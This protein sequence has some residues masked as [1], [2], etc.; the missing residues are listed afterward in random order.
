MTTPDHIDEGL[1]PVADAKPQPTNL[2][3]DNFVEPPFSVLE[4][5]SGSWIEEDRKWRALGIE[6]EIGRDDGLTFNMGM[7]FMHSQRHLESAQQ[8]SRTSVFS[9]HLC[10][11]AYASYSGP[12]HR[13][14]D[15]FAGGSV[16]GIVAGA[17][18]RAYT[19]IELRPEQVEAN[20]AQ[21]WIV[22]DGIEPRWIVGD[23]ATVLP[24]LAEDHTF[25]ADMIFSCPPYAHLEKYSDDPA[26]LS[27]MSYPDFLDAYRGIIRDSVALL[28]PNR[29]AAWVVSE[30][31]GKDGSYL[32]LVP[33][34]IRAFRDA[35]MK[36]HNDQVLLT[37]IG[38]AAVRARKQWETSRKAARVHEYML[39]FVKGDARKATAAAMGEA[40]DD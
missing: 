39:V 17:M 6:S 40:D 10:R 2:L 35:G 14:L 25:E 8:A 4:R 13:V 37:P 7:D 32:G 12:G 28:R 15:P 30:V 36:F 34:T 18:G 1:F 22:G 26:D 31:R 16:R 23:S 33:D 11:T 3:R 5:R 21:A 20:R 38:T 24:E 29:F 19:G 9:P 27:T